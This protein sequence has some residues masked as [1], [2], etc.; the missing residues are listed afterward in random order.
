MNLILNSFEII[1]IA[2]IFLI[3]IVLFVIQHFEIEKKNRQLKVM[4][5]I[6]NVL[7]DERK[8]K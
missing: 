5:A 6:I 3:P 8:T 4:Q 1:L 2:I 7:L